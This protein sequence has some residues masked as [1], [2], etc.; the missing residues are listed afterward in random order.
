MICV[1]VPFRKHRPSS[2]C[3]IKKTESFYHWIPSCLDHLPDKGRKANPGMGRAGYVDS[4][5][6]GDDSIRLSLKRQKHGSSCRRESDSM[7]LS[8][9]A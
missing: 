7:S 6:L 9:L 3:I 4:S 2:D 8:T 1:G 5:I